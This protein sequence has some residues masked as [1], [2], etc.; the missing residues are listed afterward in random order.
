MRFRTAAALIVA[1]LGAWGVLRAQRPFKQYQAAEYEDF[2]LPPDGRV[3]PSGPA[4]VF[5]IPACTRSIIAAAVRDWISTG[6]SIIRARTGIF[7]KAYAG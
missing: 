4:R 3:K 7:S 1:A 2:P 6:P 5:T